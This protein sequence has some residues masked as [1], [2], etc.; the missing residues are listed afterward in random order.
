MV[1]NV[2]RPST[3]RRF[4][5]LFEANEAN[6]ADEIDPDN[7]PA[8]FASWRIYTAHAYQCCAVTIYSPK[9]GL[10]SHANF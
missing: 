1:I 6:S 10:K 3:Q 4:M 7:L 9:V 5:T 8:D 2:S